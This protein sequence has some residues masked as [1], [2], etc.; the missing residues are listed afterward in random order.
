MSHNLSP[1]PADTPDKEMPLR[2][3]IRALGD[4]LGQILIET[5]GRAFFDLEE[6][7]RGLSKALRADYSAASEQRLRQIIATLDLPTCTSLIR[8]FSVYFQL[9]NIAEQNHRVR[10]RRT[11]QTA[12]HPLPQRGSLAATL[13]VLLQRGLTAPD[14]QGIIDQLSIE[15]VLTAHPT[16]STR[17]SVLTKSRAIADHLARR[18]QMALTVRERSSLELELAKQVRLIWRTAE[19]RSRRPD[20][21]DEVKGGLFFVEEILFA[22]I[23]DLYQVLAEQ[24]ARCYPGHPFHIPPFLRLGSWRG[25]DADGNPYVTAQVSDETLRLARQS[26]V[27]A[28]RTTIRTLAVE[29]SQADGYTPASTALRA[30]LAADES[31]LPDFAASLVGKNDNEP[32]RRKLTFIWQKLTNTLA[33]L[34]PHQATADASGAMDA[35]YH[36]GSDLLADLRVIYDSLLDAGDGVLAHGALLRLLRQ[37]EVFDLVLL[38][39][40]IRQNSDTINAA[41]HELLRVQNISA[42]YLDEPE[43]QR[44]IILTALLERG[45]RV[46]PTTESDDEALALSQETRRVTATFRQIRRARHEI[47][48]TAIRSFIV[49][50]T[51]AASDVLGVALL[52]QAIP[53]LSI[54][55]LFETIEDLHAAPQLMRQ[56][57]SVP[58]YRQRLTRLGDIQEIMLGYSDSSKDGGIVT[59]SW[60]LYVA[61]ERL[62]EAAQPFGVHLS[63]FHGRGGTVGRGGGPTY[64]AIMGQPQGTVNGR[65]RLTEQGE[66]ITQKYGLPDLAARNLELTVS[67]VMMASLPPHLHEQAARL[68][69]W[70]ATME[71]ISAHAFQVYRALVHDDPDFLT[72]FH[73][74][75]PIDHIAELNI[76][77]RPTRR[78]Q[79]ASITDLRAIPWVFSWM[80]SR[81]V[82]PGWFP[83]GSA[84]EKHIESLTDAASGW[85]ALQEMY[86][87]WPFFQSLI[88]NI[89]MSM[90][91][92]DLHVARL[93][94]NLVEDRTIGER[95]FAIIETEFHRTT[96]L[97]SAVTG[98]VSLLDNAPV[99]QS[100][101]A[102]RNP[103]V[104]PLSYI[105][106]DL[107]RQL[108]ELDRV[109]RVGTT[110]PR[111]GAQRDALIEAIKLT[112][113]GIAAG[114][115]NTG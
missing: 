3:D 13:D 17:A 105:Q 41:L 20:V 85:Q 5:E 65:L 71:H 31:A 24:L 84:L 16:E 98:Q 81:H 12:S 108:R 55:P 29:F 9:V 10:R 101:I 6:E 83:L 7:V 43:D 4:V 62:V 47:G 94:A 34:N 8:A 113:N 1:L 53:S 61:Q 66:V 112:I 40:D 95:I 11:Y 28:Y 36:T 100:S 26:V 25:G 21:I 68:P 74:A 67:A 63:F 39:L 103:Y 18:D 50:M 96:R 80:Q 22:E 111:A 82:L 57:L 45:R 54:L 99:L 42:N 2:R 73:Q 115:R 35:A 87:D 51:H 60:E 52:S 88:D 49:S 37:V 77:S 27:R 91:K 109:S 46:L 107:L 79:T 44:I 32:Y 70:K 38:P 93:Y 19:V 89:Q 30:S 56:M 23:A 75:T 59:S 104:D 110:D 64:Q 102:L 58:V 48:A 92:A 33:R 106:V 15:L 90:A 72:Y 78:R 97:M 86:R 69:V 76:G 114:L 14:I